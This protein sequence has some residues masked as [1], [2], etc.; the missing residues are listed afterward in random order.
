M[1]APFSFQELDE[2]GVVELP[3]TQGLAASDGVKL[4]YRAYIPEQPIASLVFYHGGG[5]HSGAGYVHL[6]AGLRDHAQIA[7]YT[8]DCR[9]HGESEGER[10]DAPSAEQLYHDVDS[11]LALAR[12]AHPDRPLFL[13]GHSSGAGLALNYSSWTSRTAVDGYV[14]VSPQLGYRSKTERSVGGEGNPFATAQLAPFI[15]NAMSSGLLMGHTK[16]VRFNYPPETLSA[17]PLIVDALSVNHSNGITPEAPSTQFANLAQ[18]F[19]L[20]IGADDELFEPEKVVAFGYLSGRVGGDSISVVVKDQK[21]LGIL[22]K[23]HEFVGPWLTE[24][25]RVAAASAG[26]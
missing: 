6:A 21:H 15:I 2:A 11:L 23:A 5:A 10:G 26:N 3:A 22:V 1:S 7:V 25:V 13:G 18:P 8:P 20:W 12:S 17:D 24:S 16:A 19:G 14:F 9:G 4:A